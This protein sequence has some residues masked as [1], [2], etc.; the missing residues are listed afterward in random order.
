M[1]G[2][3]LLLSLH[4]VT[5]RHVRR[6]ARAEALFRDLGVTHA[7]YLLVPRYHGGWPVETN[8][9]FSSWCREPRPFT[10]H[11]CLHGYYHEELRTGR[12]DRR[13]L[14]TWLQRR[15]LTAGE[16]EFLSLS[17]AEVGDRIDRGREAF[18]G[19]LGA[20][21]MAFVAPAW[22]FNRALTPALAERG[23]AWTEDHRR[24]Y[25]LQHRTTI[26]APVITWASRT[27]ARRWG[28]IWL[29]PR[30]L[31]RW[32]D[33]PI[34]RIALHPFDFDHPRMVE[35]IGHTIAAALRDRA[36]ES[37]EPVLASAERATHAVMS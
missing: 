32:H 7:T 17:A 9:E 2:R 22:L 15:F 35:T 11:W 6:L 36:A 27:R 12:T 3:T 18:T 5:P 13:S 10:V 33:T 20:D 34:V 25:D 31:Q 1:R 8:A 19:C 21:P 23:F 29:A 24:I 30:L 28:S 16:G 4:D 26:D 14:R 37:Y